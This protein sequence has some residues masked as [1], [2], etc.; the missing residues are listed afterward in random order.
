MIDR[1]SFQ[2]FDRGKCS[3]AGFFRV[4]PGIDQEAGA[5]KAVI[6]A[7]STDFAPASER[8]EC[9]F[10][11]NEFLMLASLC[12]GTKIT[13]FA[14]KGLCAK[15]ALLD[16]ASFAPS[17]ASSTAKNENLRYKHSNES[18]QFVR[19]AMLVNV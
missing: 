12:L 15:R 11:Q 10:R 4:Q 1:L 7:V 3:P 14:P 19:S 5:I 9:E 13:R 16:R 17:P 18:E 8:H 6:K 2:R